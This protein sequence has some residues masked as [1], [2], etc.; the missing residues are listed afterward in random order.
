MLPVQSRDGR[1]LSR[2][3]VWC[4]LRQETDEEENNGPVGTSISTLSNNKRICYLS[5]L[6]SNK[7]E[8]VQKK[9]IR[10]INI[11]TN[12]FS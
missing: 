1:T 11:H 4:G 5:I 12:E 6:S 10:E 8:F 3:P 9:K 7:K 2:S